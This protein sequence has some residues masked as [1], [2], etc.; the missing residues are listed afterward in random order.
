MSDA[1]HFAEWPKLIN[2]RLNELVPET[3]GPT[4]LIYQ[5]VRYSLLGS[6]KRI[7]P[8]FAL[9][10]AEIFN[11]PL[12]HVLTP[13]CALEMIHAYSLIHDDLPCMDD[14]DFRRGKPSL[15]KAFNEAIAVL[16]G[17][18]LMNRAFEVLAKDSALPPPQAI[19]LIAVLTAMSGGDGMIGGQLMDMEAETIAVD[20]PT[21]SLIHQKKTGALMRASI[22]F[23]AIL[24]QASPDERQH[25]DAFGE[26]IGLAF[27][28]MDDILDIT[29][30]K[31]KRGNETS[32]DTVNQKSTYVSLMGIEAARTIALDLQ[33]SAEQSLNAIARNTDTLRFIAQGILNQ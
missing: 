17:D 3:S 14:D 31:I 9:A 33:K 13:C 7:R 1:K 23:G 4:Q 10:A 12:Q 2:T 11:T 25:L 29:S 32:S 8:V 19:E 6:G 27:Q 30:P 18:F 22:A 21:L 5:A 24:G 15:H 16:A 26:K 20:L 28:V